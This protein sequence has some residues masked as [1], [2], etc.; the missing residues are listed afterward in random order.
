MKVI[1]DNLNIFVAIIINKVQGY[2]SI[3]YM[4]NLNSKKIKK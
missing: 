2:D 1:K 4:N 3:K